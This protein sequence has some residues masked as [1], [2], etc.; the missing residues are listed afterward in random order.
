MN[1][2]LK[3]C[4]QAKSNETRLTVGGKHAGKAAGATENWTQTVMDVG[5]QDAAETALTVPRE[6]R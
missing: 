5:V 3:E 1:T 6:E 2:S 4:V